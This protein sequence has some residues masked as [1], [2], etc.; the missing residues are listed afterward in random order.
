MTPR[1]YV[2]SP[3]AAATRLA[4]P[5]D[6]AHHVGRVLRMRVGEPLI[7]FDGRGGEYTAT[8][9]R[10]G[11]GTAEV[12]LVAHSPQERESPLRIILAQGISRGE[13]M[14]YTIQKAVELG[15]A[16]IQPVITTRSTVRLD[17]QRARRRHEHWRR[18]IIGACE[19][20]GRNLLPRLQPARDLDAWLADSAQPRLRL[21]LDGGAEGE[22]A[23]LERPADMALSLLVGPEGGLSPEEI[24]QAMD[25]GHRG[26]RLGPRVLRT[27]TA[28]LAAM[29][30]LQ[31]LWGDFR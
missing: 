1:I 23:G 31:G 8:L 10:L 3:L 16:V 5:A 19:Q 9:T 13:R 20:C 25:A 28:A 7:L 4:L 26:L 30:L 29:A 15:V 2:D 14:D 11:R 17:A 21:L 22:A 18:I 6:S 12:A 27:E 24:V